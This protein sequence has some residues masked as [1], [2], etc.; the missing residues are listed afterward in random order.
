MFIIQTHEVS[1]LFMDNHENTFLELKLTEKRRIKNVFVN[2]TNGLWH[3]CHLRR[4]KIQ[5]DITLNPRIDIT[6]I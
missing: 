4:S 1:F 3:I 2:V 6:N 5:N